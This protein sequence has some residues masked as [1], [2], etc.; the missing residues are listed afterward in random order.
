MLLSSQPSTQKSFMK[1]TIITFKL[2]AL[3]SCA[4]PSLLLAQGNLIPSGA[5]GPTMKTLTQVEPRTPIS[6]LP[7]VITNSGSYYLTANL[8]GI[9]GT[10]GIT[11]TADNV[12][13]DLNGFALNGVPGS[14]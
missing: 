12:T 14:S 5:P 10:N 6:S 7:L 11:I 3:L 2:G 9:V 1:K 13:I 8:T 4:V